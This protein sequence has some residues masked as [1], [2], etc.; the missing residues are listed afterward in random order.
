MF[1]RKSHKSMLS[2]DDLAIEMTDISVMYRIP[3]EPVTTL[4]ETVVRQLK[5][6]RVNYREIWALQ[7]VCLTLRVGQAVSLI[8]RNG[9]GKSTLLR[10]IARVLSPT[11]GR[12][13]A[14]G[15]IA[16]LIELGL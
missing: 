5:G 2:S 4:K 6:R 14:F 16:P 8:G 15:S 3:S 1:N 7:N 13:R 11:K 12:V 10:V 9:S